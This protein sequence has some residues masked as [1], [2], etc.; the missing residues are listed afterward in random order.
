MTFSKKYNEIKSLC[1]DEL[2]IIE[3]KMISDISL[4]QPLDKMVKDF[5][6]YPSKRVRSTLATLI[7]KAG[8]NMVTDEQLEVLSVVELIHNASLIH[9]DVIDDDKLRR[10][11]KTLSAEFDNKLAIIS[12]DYL[13]SL[14]MQKLVKLKNLE[15]INLFCKTIEKMCLG[16][17]EQNFSKY[18]IGTLEQYLEKTKNKTAY[19]FE[20][21]LLSCMML[22]ANKSYLAR[23]SKIG[24]NIGI[25]FQI[26][27][28]IL[29]FTGTDD[30]K[31]SN[32]DLREGIYNAPVILG[33][34]TDNWVSGIEKTKILLNN[35]IKEAVDELSYLGE[36]K[37]QSAIMNFLE[38]LR[39]V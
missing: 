21:A 16:E 4:I 28:D 38:L 20:T 19:L 17:V 14:A 8:K 10:G 36:N 26:R 33:E 3:E 30:T 35:Y 6:L 12:G 37:Y 32:S 1:S 24:I 39:D 15:V 34:K 22:G 18:K 7:V 11:H 9:D 2:S 25:A 23:I 27:D 5:L 31:P 29:N 13:L